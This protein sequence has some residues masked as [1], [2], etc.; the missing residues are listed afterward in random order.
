MSSERGDGCYKYVDNYF[1]SVFL[2]FYVYYFYCEDV[3]KQGTLL[4]S[5]LKEVVA[6]VA[7]VDI[8]EEAVVD[9][10]AVAVAVVEVE[11]EVEVA[12]SMYY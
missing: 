9:T 6:M 4:V 1:I 3:E 12:T 2:I 11:V 5:A 8:A 7:A 10:V